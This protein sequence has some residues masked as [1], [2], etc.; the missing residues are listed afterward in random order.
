VTLHDV[1]RAPPLPQATEASTSVSSAAPCALP[2]A[3]THRQITSI[4]LFAGATEV[5][6]DHHGVIYRLKQ[7]SLGKLILTK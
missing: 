4:H 1:P 6:I 3:D 7:T 5:R 2:L